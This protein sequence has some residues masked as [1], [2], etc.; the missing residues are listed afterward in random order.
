MNGNRSS[1][2]AACAALAVLAL[3]LIAPQRLA[4]AAASAHGATNA[5]SASHGGSLPDSLLARVGTHRDVSLA[6]FRRAWSAIAPPQ[7]PDSLTPD[8]ARKFLDLLIDKEVLGEVAL[9]T[10]WIW[11][12]RESAEVAGLE[13]RLTLGAALDSALRATQAEHAARGDTIRDIELLG[14]VT[15]DST[16]ARLAAVFDTALTRRLAKAWAA[17]PKPSPDSSLM[18]QLRVLGTLPVIS[19]DDLDRVLARSSDG[20][21][22]VH[23]L[24]SSWGALS[25]TQRPRVS[26][27]AQIEDLAR[28]ALFERLLRRDARRRDLVHRPDIAASLARKREYLAVTHLVARDVYATLEADSL[29]LLRYYRAHPGEFDLPLRVRLVQLELPDR[30]AASR[31]ALELSD[32]VKAD[33]LVARGHRRHAEYLSELSR[34]AD[35]LL[36]DRALASRP[37]S[38]L[39][40]DSTANGW[41]VVRVMEVV[42]PRARTFAEARPFVEHAWYGEE[43][44]RRMVALIAKLRTQTTIQRNDRAFAHLIAAGPSAPP[45]GAAR[46]TP[47]PA[48]R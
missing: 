2:R 10:T 3:E 29:T 36:F 15:R 44:E 42:A 37:G 22:L 33:S 45:P 30:A 8:A 7:R 14:T 20:D 27:P 21:I 12:A 23:E 35:S 19:K 39:G 1:I 24:L 16:V 28:N 46:L 13:D 5:N 11:T 25:P 6:G 31:M 41:S 26:T 4:H 40:P 38:V 47:A 32:P 18:S 48:N 34:D 17:I 43:G 9:R